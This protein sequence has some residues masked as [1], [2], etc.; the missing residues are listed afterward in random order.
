MRSKNLK[1]FLVSIYFDPLVI[2]FQN[3]FLAF[4]IIALENIL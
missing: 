3:F 2:I 1:D 4:L